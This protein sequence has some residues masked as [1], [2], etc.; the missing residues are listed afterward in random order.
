M[1]SKRQS[2]SGFFKEHKE[3]VN[4]VSHFQK[5]TIENLCDSFDEG[6]TVIDGLWDEKNSDNCSVTSSLIAFASDCK[7]NNL[8]QTFWR[9]IMIN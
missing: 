5:K 3:V 1:L 2:V 7:Y 8:F 4:W 9:L 6:E